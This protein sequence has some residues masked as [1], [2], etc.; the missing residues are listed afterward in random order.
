MYILSTL[1]KP[2]IEFIQITAPVLGPLRLAQSCSLQR[3]F[4]DIAIL[5]YSAALHEESVHP[6]LRN[7]V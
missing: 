4:L 7:L 1:K 6:N 2:A 3:A 5:Y